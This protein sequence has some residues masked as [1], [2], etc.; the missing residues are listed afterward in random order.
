MYNNHTKYFPSKYPIICAGMNTVSDLKL[1]LAVAEAG[2]Y[3]SFVAFNY[4]TIVEGRFVHNFKSMFDELTEF[5]YKTGSSNFILSVT[6]ALLTDNDNTLEI[7]K[8]IKP[9]Y[10]ELLDD[11]FL[12]DDKYKEVVKILR[13]H[14]I[15]ILVKVLSYEN[16]V[17]EIIN[18][19]TSLVDGIIIKNSK[20]AGRVATEV[21]NIFESIQLIKKSVPEWIIVS[22]GGIYDSNGIKDHL[23]AGADM[24]SI[25]T[26][27]AVSEESS[28][29][30]E[31][32]TKMIQS[33]YADTVKIGTANQTGLLF[34]KQRQDVENNTIGLR[35]GIRTGKDGHVFAGAGL[36]HVDRIQSVSAIVQNLVTGL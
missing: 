1:A 27:F 12:T 33:S 18:K 25:G 5:V 36:D 32:K 24:V 22:Q 15:K 6:T 29:S 30:L 21:E 19:D 26:V 9:A 4:F 2:C 10:I 31:A 28:I 7:L 11:E 20:A 23:F 8:N 34:S 17:T 13:D 3:P 16:G 14:N 35:R